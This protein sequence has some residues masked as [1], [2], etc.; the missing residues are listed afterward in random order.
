MV[1]LLRTRPHIGQ[2]R[3]LPHRMQ[4]VAGARSVVRATLM[5]ALSRRRPEIGQTRRG[6]A[7]ISGTRVARPSHPDPGI[8]VD[9]RLTA[10]EMEQFE[11]GT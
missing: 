7:R 6:Q 11:I 8:I 2:A 3:G 1:A 4:R 9:N 10:I 5:V